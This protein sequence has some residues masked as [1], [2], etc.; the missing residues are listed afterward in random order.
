MIVETKEM[1]EAVAVVASTVS[2]SIEGM[3]YILL[4]HGDDTYIQAYN[5]ERGVRCRLPASGPP[6][7]AMLP[8]D[9]FLPLIRSLKS[10]EISIENNGST[11]IVKS[12]KERFCYNTV[13]YSDLCVVPSP[14]LVSAEADDV[15]DALKRARFACDGE[16]QRVM[17]INGLQFLDG[18]TIVGTNGLRI[19]VSKTKVDGSIGDGMYILPSGTADVLIS[20]L[21]SGKV[22]FG[23]TSNAALFQNGVVTIWS[24]LISGNYPAVY[25]ATKTFGDPD[26]LATVDP[27][28]F[29]AAIDRIST[30][31]DAST[32]G[33]TMTMKRNELALSVKTSVGNAEAS[34]DVEYDGPEQTVSVDRRY[35]QQAVGLTKDKVRVGITKEKK[36]VMVK[37]NEDCSYTSIYA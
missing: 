22:E 8:K 29:I 4:N 35:I 33:M 31:S 34:V 21:V 30:A 23:F 18:L 19:A 25:Q 11:V 5:G 12:G 17:P 20:S 36:T 24:T 16:S 27:T 32:S 26:V 1:K 6:M 14:K 13:A 15:R 37:I 7:K 28:E 10:K 9:R 3:E 2:K